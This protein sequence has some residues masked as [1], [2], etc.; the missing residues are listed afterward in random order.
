MC[1]LLKAE[2]YKNELEKDL[3]IVHCL[4]PL[5]VTN[6]MRPVYIWC[7]NNSAKFLFTLSIIN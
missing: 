3:F 5:F 1:Y 4:T 7:A 6:F 2:F